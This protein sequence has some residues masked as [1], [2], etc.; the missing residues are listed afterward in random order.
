MDV[1]ENTKRVAQQ[2]LDYLRMYPE[3]HDQNNFVSWEDASVEDLRHFTGQVNLCDTTMCVAGT[4]QWQ[5]EGQIV[6]SAVD[7]AAGDYLGLD[8]YEW[9]SLFYDTNNEQAIDMLT[10]IANGDADKFHDL[11]RELL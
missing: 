1:T 6:L 4:V 11:R 8:R 7:Y 10:A 3:R 9:S 2:A 5:Q